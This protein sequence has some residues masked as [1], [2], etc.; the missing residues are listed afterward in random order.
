[1]TKEMK[2]ALVAKYDELTADYNRHWQKYNR[3]CSANDTST[4]VTAAHIRRKLDE[5]DHM[6]YGF[7]LALEVMGYTISTGSA[8]TTID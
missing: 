2:A 1:M 8:G 6:Q 3:I 5:I 7:C 4:V